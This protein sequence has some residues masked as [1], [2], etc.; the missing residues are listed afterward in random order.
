MSVSASNG[1]QSG[2]KRRPSTRPQNGRAGTRSAANRNKPLVRPAPRSKIRRAR[3]VV[4]KVDTWSVAKLMFLLSVAVG[5]VIVVTSVVLWLVLQATG[6]FD[7]INDML[8]MLGT[9]GNHIDISQVLSLGQVALY[10]TILAV[11]NVIL[12]T[13]LSVICAMLY[14]IAAKLVGGIGLTL[15]DD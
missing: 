15:T 7:G 11:V 9:T 12:F 14:N 10:T 5:I 6:A 2:A 1:A 3:L 4:A 8:T 13:L